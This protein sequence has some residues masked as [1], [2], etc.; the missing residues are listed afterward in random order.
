VFLAKF[1]D[2]VRDLATV[3]GGRTVAVIGGVNK[4]SAV[5]EWM[6]GERTPRGVDAE[7]RLRL[8]Y[9]VVSILRDRLG[10]DETVRAWMLGANWHLKDQS[11]IAVIAR[12][13]IDQ[14]AKA[15]LGTTR[16]FVAQL[17]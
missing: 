9:Q 8:A 16:E 12:G 17:S 10:D 1:S 14:A 4:T 13:P 7:R 6:R 5:G 11:P 15:V 3:L 2:V